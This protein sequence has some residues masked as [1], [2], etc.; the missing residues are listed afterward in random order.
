MS[1]TPQSSRLLALDGLRGLAALGIA[2]EHYALLP[3]QFY[4]TAG[5]YLRLHLCADVFF[6]MSGF[7]LAHRYLT[8]LRSGATSYGAFLVGRIAR[9]YPLHIFMLVLLAVVWR[10][11]GF[12]PTYVQGKT[13]TFVHALL[14]TDALGFANL[15]PTWNSVTWSLTAELFGGCFL[16][17]LVRLGGS[18][19]ALGVFL[20]ALAAAVHAAMGWNFGHINVGH[21]MATSMLSWPLLRGTSGIGLGI[22]AYLLKDTPPLRAAAARGALV[23]PLA[24]VAGVPLF[25]G[26]QHH[27]AT[28]F[29]LPWLLVLVLPALAAGRGVL[30]AL[31]GLRGLRTL[32]ALSFAIYLG[33]WAAI[34]LMYGAQ[35]DPSRGAS[36]AAYLL[37]LL[38]LAT[39]AHHGIEKPLT[40][41][42]RAA[43]HAAFVRGPGLP[44][45]RRV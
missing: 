32:G 34:A 40:A 27:S 38:G 29:F 8:S 13:T 33:N 12:E 15:E 45:A 36:L 10:L 30:P 18:L 39:V 43:L 25:L 41:R 1:S 14:L 3:R 20:A 23:L 19:R 11:I 37:G 16:F 31:L 9:I 17:A 26:S 5:L 4:L 22:L 2:V 44:A 7:V 21:G 6:V 42:L 35:A 28:D 24:A